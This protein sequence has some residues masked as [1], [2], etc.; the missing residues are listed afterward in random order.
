MP[1]IL[2]WPGDPEVETY[3][4]RLFR[5]TERDAWSPT[6]PARRGRFLRLRSASWVNV[7]ARTPDGDIVFIE[8]YRHGTQ[9]ITLEIPGGI[10]EDGEDP[11][12]AALRELREETGYVGSSARLL[13]SVEVNPAI[14]DNRCYMAFVDDCTESADPDPDEHE[15][16]A[17]RLHREGEVGGLVR[18]GRV[19]HSLVVAA[20]H[21]LHLDRSKPDD[22]PGA[23]SDESSAEP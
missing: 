12:D 18:D 15:E 19:T 2:H 14:Q 7:I 11:L 1:T 13:G 22:A 9:N 21:L 17:V 5:I 23:G 8:Q 20:F 3:R 16:I 10:V 6:R 4:S